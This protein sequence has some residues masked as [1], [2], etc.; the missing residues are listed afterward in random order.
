MF[1][2]AYTRS[3]L[4]GKVIILKT[5]EKKLMEFVFISIEN[6]KVILTGVLKFY[7]LSL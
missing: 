7:S 2:G 5:T 1:N 3:N 6:V 4:F